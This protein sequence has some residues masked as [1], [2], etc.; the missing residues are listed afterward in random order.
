MPW[1]GV[2]GGGV[3]S[4]AGGG[5]R[6]RCRGWGQGHWWR[7]LLFL[8]KG[9]AAD[10]GYGSGRTSGRAGCALAGGLAADGVLIGDGVSGGGGCFSVGGRPAVAGVGAGSLAAVAA[11]GRGERP[12]GVAAFGERPLAAQ[13]TVWPGGGR[14]AMAVP[15]AGG[16]GEAAAFMMVSVGVVMRECGRQLAEG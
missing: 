2:T 10:G 16:G 4:W 7:R 15:G 3:C 9:G 1:F 5:A 14:P 11:L 13:A 12:V 6:R 8:R